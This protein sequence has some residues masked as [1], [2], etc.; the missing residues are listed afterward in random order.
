M[1]NSTRIINFDVEFN[2]QIIILDVEFYKQINNIDVEFN[3]HFINLDVEFN[4]HIIN[5]LVDV[6]TSNQPNALE[7]TN[8]EFAGLITA[9][10][11]LC[12]PTHVVWIRD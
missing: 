3:K 12:M 2:K 6:Q 8:N 10:F 5:L 11:V 9:P 7:R 4:K 1:L